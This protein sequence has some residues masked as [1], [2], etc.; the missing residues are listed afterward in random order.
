[1]TKLIVAF[2]NVVKKD[3]K[4]HSFI[5]NVELCVLAVCKMHYLDE[6]EKHGNPKRG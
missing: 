6:N 3:L 4:L 1:M 5:T 2:R